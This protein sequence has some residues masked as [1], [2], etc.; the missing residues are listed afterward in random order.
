MIATAHRLEATAHPSDATG[1]HPDGTAHPSDATAPHPDVT[2]PHREGQ[3]RQAAAKVLPENRTCRESPEISS[4]LAAIR[5]AVAAE[6]V[7]EVAVA[8]AAAVVTIAIGSSRVATNSGVEPTIRL[9]PPALGQRVVVRRPRKKKVPTLVLLACSLPRRTLTKVGRCER[10]AVQLFPL[11][12]KPDLS[13]NW[14]FSLSGVVIKYAEPPE[15][16]KPRERWRLYPFKD[17]KP[18]EPLYIH[19]QSAYLIGRDPEV[20]SPWF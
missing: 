5:S 9:Q 8:V 12:S 7:G 18:L 19:R 1:L 20:S 17:G 16:R 6:A 11:R 13:K 3:Y 4:G 2:D 10:A 15:A 14:P